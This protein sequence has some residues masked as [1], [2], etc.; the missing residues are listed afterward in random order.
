VHPRLGD[1]LASLLHVM[2]IVLSGAPE[3]TKKQ[4]K[5]PKSHKLFLKNE[6]I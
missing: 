5:P 1:V 4:Q 6:T 3:K 2:F